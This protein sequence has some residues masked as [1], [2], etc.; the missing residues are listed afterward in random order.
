MSALG[1]GGAVGTLQRVIHQYAQLW[2]SGNRYKRACGYGCC[3]LA[4]QSQLKSS[5]GVRN[6]R[7]QIQV[8]LGA[9]KELPSR[10]IAFQSRADELVSVA[11]MVE[12]ARHSPTHHNQSTAVGFG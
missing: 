4:S 9:L 7:L 11:S 6:C 3:T 5:E 10:Q 8:P 2:R 12:E 1:E